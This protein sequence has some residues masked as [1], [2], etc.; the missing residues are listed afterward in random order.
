M[1]VFYETWTESESGW[2]Q[3]PDGCSLH[4]SKEERN[5]YVKEYWSEMPDETPVEYSRPDDNGKYI[6][7]PDDHKIVNDLKKEK[8]LRFW[9]GD[10]G[11]F[12]ISV[13]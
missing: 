13:K 4:V 11:K 9:H 2:G 7:I 3:R 8:S 5:K 6:D 1:K 12:G 10:L